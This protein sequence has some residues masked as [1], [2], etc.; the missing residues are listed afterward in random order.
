MW[1]K[2]ALRAVSL[3][4]LFLVVPG[5]L[6]WASTC[7]SSTG[8][9]DC[10]TLDSGPVKCL[11]VNSSASCTCTISFF[12][13]SPQCALDGVCDYTPPGGGG[14]G[15]GTGGG[16]SG[17]TRTAGEWCPAECDSCRTVYW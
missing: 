11:F 2:T 5:S 3:A 6:G 1:W 15:G 9:V 7:S 14:G 13:G 8:C 4:A 17:C 10:A 16:G 12:G